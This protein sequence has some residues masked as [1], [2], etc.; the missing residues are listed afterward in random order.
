MQGRRG[1]VGER[2]SSAVVVLA[3]ADGDSLGAEVKVV[4][5]ESVG[6]TCAQSAAVDQLQKRQIE[7]AF[8]I[9]GT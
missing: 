7:P 8:E 6:F 9:R 2:K 1:L 3:S 4:E 5:G